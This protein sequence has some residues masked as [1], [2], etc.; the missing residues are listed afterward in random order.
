M[1]PGVWLMSGMPDELRL[2]TPLRREAGER[3]S[4]RG[5]PSLPLV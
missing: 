3:A 1:G 4:E 2:R 5:R